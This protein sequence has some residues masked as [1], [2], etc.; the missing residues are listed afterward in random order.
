M[1]HF[2]LSRG[3]IVTLEGEISGGRAHDDG[4]VL[5][6]ARR[7]AGELEPDWD[8]IEQFEQASETF[9]LDVDGK[10]ARLE[11]QELFDERHG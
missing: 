7:V 8:R 11:E 9:D 10:Y 2:E 4:E 3:R 1:L 6:F 5:I